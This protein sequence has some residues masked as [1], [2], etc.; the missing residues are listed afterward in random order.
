MPIMRRDAN[1]FQTKEQELEERLAVCEK[2]LKTLALLLPTQTSLGRK[3][4]TWDES[5]RRIRAI[6]DEVW[7]MTDVVYRDST[8]IDFVDVVNELKSISSKL[9]TLATKLGG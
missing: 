1:T 7:G 9:H 3:D 2:Q 4:L 5:V 6:G 8:K